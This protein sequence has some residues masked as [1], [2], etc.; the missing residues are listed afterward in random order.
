MTNA[1]PRA[2][3]ALPLGAAAGSLATIA[4]ALIS[5]EL[6]TDWGSLT[7]ALVVVPLFAVLA[8]LLLT[9]PLAALRRIAWVGVPL[10]LIISVV[11]GELV[12]KATLGTGFARWSAAR[13]W[14]AAEHRAQ[15]AREAAERDVCRRLLAQPP[16]P[17][18]PAPPGASVGRAAPAEV[19][20]TTTG[21]IGFSR[22]RC[23]EL[24]AR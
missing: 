15:T 13:H 16:I 3:P 2:W 6:Y 23:A 11:A 14:A 8:A 5:P 9:L 17:P 21:L 7:G 1:R 20:E 12:F 4:A 19:G 18:P 22:K 10:G 24:L